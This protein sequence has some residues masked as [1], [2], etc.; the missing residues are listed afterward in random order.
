MPSIMERYRPKAK[1]EAQKKKL[2]LMEDY[3]SQA[4]KFEKFF[5]KII[6]EHAEFFSKDKV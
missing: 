1:T 2:R 4:L 6:G 5:E 3:Y